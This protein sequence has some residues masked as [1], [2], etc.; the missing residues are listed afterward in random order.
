[1]YISQ[2]ILHPVLLLLNNGIWYRV[3]SWV[4]LQ[5]VRYFQWCWPTNDGLVQTIY[6]KYGSKIFLYFLWRW[7]FS[8]QNEKSNHQ[9]SLTYISGWVSVNCWKHFYWYHS[10]NYGFRSKWLVQWCV[11]QQ[12][13]LL[14]SWYYCKES[15]IISIID[16]WCF[17]LIFLYHYQNIRN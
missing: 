15:N 6:K 4:T 2:S 12:I 5:N 13:Y 14:L 7:L 1:M 9:K 16:L 8:R 3:R 17:P 11:Y 10:N